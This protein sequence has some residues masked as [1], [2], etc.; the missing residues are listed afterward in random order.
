MK[1]KFNWKEFTNK[2]NHI[3]VRCETESDAIKFCKLMD[4]HNMKWF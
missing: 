4:S 1:S 2:S 3:I